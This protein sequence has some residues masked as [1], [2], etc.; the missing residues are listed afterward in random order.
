VQLDVRRIFLGAVVVSLVLTAGIA[1]V[2]LLLGDFGETEARILLTTASISFFSLLALPGS[3]LVEQQRLQP[4][5]LTSVGLAVL[6]F[7]LALNMIWVQWDDAGEG[8]WK[9][10]LVVTIV[11]VATTQAAGVELRRRDTDSVWVRRLALASH[12][13]AGLAA[14]LASIA[15]IDE[16]DDEGF[17]RALGALVVVNVLLVA[18]QPVLRRMGRA[19]AA[20]DRVARVE[21]E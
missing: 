2:T 9:S 21:R 11:A 3:I 6:G 8:S 18:L 15:V 17:L 10:L 4:L 12:A 20:G 19:P 1:I 14:L 16:L 5:A 7:V 13:A